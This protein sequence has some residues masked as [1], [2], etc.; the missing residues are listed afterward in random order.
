MG[1]KVKHAPSAAAIGESAYT[2]GKGQRRERDIL[3]ATDVALK[4]QAMGLQARGLAAQARAQEGQRALGYAQIESR[5][6]QQEAE[7][8]FRKE[9]WQDT[10]GLKLQVR[11][12]AQ[13]EYR[14]K[15]T[16]IR[17]TPAQLK[18]LSGL[19]DGIA[20]VEK[21]YAVGKWTLP[22]LEELLGQFEFIRERIIPQMVFDDTR[23][24]QENFE[25]QIVAH[26]QTG[27]QYYV[28][29]QTGKLLPLGM[30]EKDQGAMLTDFM[31]AMKTV[32]PMSGNDTTDYDEVL[33]QYNR[34]KA[35]FA[36]EDEL[37]TRVREIKRLQAEEQAQ[38]PQELDAEVKAEVEKLPEMFENISKG[39]QPK[40]GRQGYAIQ[41]GIVA[42]DKVL[43]E[44]A[45]NLMLADAKYRGK[46]LG[47][48]PDV[49]ETEFAKWWY[50]KFDEERGEKFQKYQNPME[51]GGAAQESAAELRKG[52]TRQDYNR[53]VELGYW[54]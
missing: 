47:I 41:P 39:G 27:K 37:S 10:L 8:G 54:E 53:G 24:P 14:R 5:E 1:I 28:D 21:E 40:I 52:G 43:G 15:H 6:E 44:E 20:Q 30:S 26:P 16:K 12:D 13:E 49:V 22:Q 48:P 18:T 4:Q 29:P 2:I 9:Q 35:L 31:V 17:Y 38:Q 50:S 51:F 7:L 19:A 45:Y 46:Q 36:K 3:L 33:I 11:L 42:T 25:L 32:D 34:A 23:G